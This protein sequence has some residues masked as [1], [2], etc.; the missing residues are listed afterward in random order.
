MTSAT[1]RRFAFVAAMV[2]LAPIWCRP[3]SV[4]RAVETPGAVIAGLVDA[5]AAAAPAIRRH[6]P[7]G[8][9]MAASRASHGRTLVVLGT[10]ALLALLGLAP[11]ARVQTVRRAPSPLVRRRHVIALRAPPLP[12]CVPQ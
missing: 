1:V 12:F 8:W 6:A 2:L 3:A 10:L 9:W 5:G 7:A 4:T 11:W